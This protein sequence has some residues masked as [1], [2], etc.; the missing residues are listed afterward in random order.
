VARA[1]ALADLAPGLEVVDIGC[2]RGEA[3]L[4]AARRG[5]RVTALDFSLEGLAM[6]GASA[7]LGPPRRVRLAAADASR[8]PLADGCADRVLL[9]DVVE[10]LTPGDLG[11]ALAEVRR[12]LAPAGRV[13]IHTLPNRHALAAYQLVA[14]LVPGLPR[15]P[16]SG[17]ERIVHVNEQSRGDLRRALGAAGFESRVWVEE[18][19]T[20]NAAQRRGVRFPDRPRRDGYPVLARPVFR[21][22]ARLAMTT[23]LGP[24][25]GNDLFALAWHVRSAPPRTGGRM[26]PVR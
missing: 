2:G 19:T 4:H 15:D 26:G 6:T 17:Y 25:V 9:L 8:L 12:I 14:P 23:P 24:L 11:R 21:R 1:L 7:R 18:W 20:R 22:L 16:R 3:A 13:V 10:H 5:C